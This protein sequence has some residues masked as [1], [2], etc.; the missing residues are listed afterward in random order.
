MHNPPALTA[1]IERTRTLADRFEGITY[2]ASHLRYF[3]NF[4]TAR[5]L[6]CA[7][8]GPAGSRYV[9]AGGAA[10]LYLALDP[11]TAYREFNQDYFRIARIPAGRALSRSGRLRPAPCVTFGVHLRMTRLLMLLRQTPR[12]RQTRRLLAIK[13]DAELLGP[14]LG[15]PNPPTHLLGRAVFDDGYFKGIVYPSLQNRGHVCIVL[16]R[17][18]LLPTSWVDVHD[19]ETG[20]LEQIP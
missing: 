10:A 12:G 20:V 8:A 13:R 3:S 9:P 14:W 11:D 19:V 15:I 2:R 16:F 18:R 1:A 4:A 6:F 17:D 5:P 7:A